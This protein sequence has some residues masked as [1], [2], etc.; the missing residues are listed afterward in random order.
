MRTPSCLIIGLLLISMAQEAQAATRKSPRAVASEFYALV[1]REDI[2]GL[3]DGQEMRVL[4]PYLSRSLRSLFRRAQK[5]EAEAIRRTP[6]GD[7]PPVFEG[8]L[9]SCLYEGPQKFR[10]GRQKV[11]GRLAYVKV[12]QSAGPD[13]WADTLILV[14]ERGRWLVWDVRMGCREPHMGEL[15]LRKVLGDT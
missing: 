7:K 12:E 4:G 15:T 13:E 14:M 9:F 11:S 6:A 5:S 3:P 10:I 8:S 2:S 1:V